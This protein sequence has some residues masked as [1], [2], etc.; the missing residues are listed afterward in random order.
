MAL[1]KQLEVK[2]S[3]I[4]GAGRGLFTNKLIP[5]GTKI[6]EYKGKIRT[7][8]EVENNYSNY[9]IFYVN[10]NHI[11]D[12]ATFKSPGKYIN[13]AKGLQYYELYILLFKVYSDNFFGK[14]IVYFF[15]MKAL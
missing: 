7:W 2:E 15:L 8:K 12:A 10:E 4:A 3:N 14:T 13:D 5:K 9:Y 1:E 6:V 11:I